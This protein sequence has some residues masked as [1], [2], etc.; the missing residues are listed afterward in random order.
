MASSFRAAGK[1]QRNRATA[2]AAQGTGAEHKAGGSGILAA[3]MFQE[4]HLLCW[5]R[6]ERPRIAPACPL[7]A[8]RSS[9]PARRRGTSGGRP[10][11]LS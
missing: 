3:V 11:E 8:H 1:G 4:K 6:E 7:R 9:L 5:R 10:A 2:P